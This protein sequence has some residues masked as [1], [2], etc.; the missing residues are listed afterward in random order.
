MPLTPIQLWFFGQAIPDR[1]HWNQSVL[2]HAREALRPEALDAALRAVVAHHDALRLRYRQDETGAWLAEHANL[3]EEQTRWVEEPLLWVRAARDPAAAEPLYEEAQRSLNLGEGPLLRA[4][5]VE[6]Q[7]GAG[8][9][10]LAIHHLVADGVSWRILLEDLQSAYAQLTKRGADH[11][12]PVLPAKTT[13]FK[14]WSERLR[15]YAKSPALAGELPYWREQLKTEGAAD[16]PRDHIVETGFSRD[17][18]RAFAR[19]DRTATGHLLK[20]APEAYR[21]QIND[22]LLTALARTLCRWSGAPSAL[23]EL[24]GH[25]REDLFED[26]D[27]AGRSAGSQ[28]CSR[29]V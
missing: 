29:S 9:L 16:P 12:Q 19:L 24:E 3:E 11:A 22:L 2:L 13:S 25:G 6:L 15:T 18:A 17:A 28:A 7:D 8:H 14:V 26:L 5:Y 1:A 20:Q 27:S 10:L 21:T 23:V 4:L